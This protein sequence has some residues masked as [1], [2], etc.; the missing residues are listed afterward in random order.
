MSGGVGVG[1]RQEPRKPSW[2]A[3]GA[4]PPHPPSQPHLSP[5]G[6]AQGPALRRE[7]A[8]IGE[9]VTAPLPL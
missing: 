2:R 5:G 9:Q 3:E 8:P 4:I 6:H 1:G 7:G